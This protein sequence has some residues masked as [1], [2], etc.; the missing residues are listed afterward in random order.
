MSFILAYELTANGERALDIQA[1][2]PDGLTRQLPSGFY[3]TFRTLAA[4]TKVLNLRS[5]LDRL[6]TP[7]AAQGIRPAVAREELRRALARL[8]RQNA[9]GESRIRLILSASDSP[10]AMY[11]ILEPFQPLAA[12]IYQNGIRVIC[13][14]L[15]RA[16]PRLKST[17]FIE[18]SQPARQLVQG[19]T[20]E[21]LLMRSGRILEGMT[22]NFFYVKD[23]KL[24]TARK[25]I[26]LGVTRRTVLRV[27]R[28]SGLDIVYRSLKREQVPAL[29]EAFITSS[30]R[31]IVPV[32]Q[33]DDMTVGE[34]RPGSVTKKLSN[35]YNEYVIRHAEMISFGAIKP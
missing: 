13:L 6:Y 25:N 22:S 4:G 12:V 23:G 31:G 30:S 11:A 8:V 29:D 19:D 20:I 28:G 10:G 35:A 27:A 3:T 33:I 9:P 2:S 17:T 5:H 21:V 7:A 16:T 1:D 32:V 24:G 15:E 14:H 18:R 34:G 26:L